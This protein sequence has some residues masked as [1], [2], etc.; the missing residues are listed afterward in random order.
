LTF[1]QHPDR[2]LTVRDFERLCLRRLQCDLLRE[3]HVADGEPA[4]GCEALLLHRL[5]VGI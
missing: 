2:R 4:F 5:S 3:Q 1:V